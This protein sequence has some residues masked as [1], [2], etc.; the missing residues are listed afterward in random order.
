MTTNSAPHHF[1][2]RK[3]RIPC[4]TSNLGPGFDLLGLALSLW[5]EVELS[6]TSEAASSPDSTG[7]Q[8]DLAADFAASWPREN[9]LM[10]RAFDAVFA[11]Q[12]TSPP[13][14]HFRVKSEIPTAR[15]LGSSGAAVTAGLLL[16]NDV[17][18][19]WRGESHAMSTAELHRLGME[20]EGHPDN[21]TA[22]LFGGCTLC[23][24]PAPGATGRSAHDGGL[25]HAPLSSDLGFAVAW[26]DATLTTT[27]ARACLPTQVAFAD[28]VENPRRL[29]ML[30][31][32]L[33]TGNPKLLALGAEDRLHHAF[34]LALIPGGSQALQ[35]ATDAGAAMVA[36]NGSGSSLLAIGRVDQAEQLGQT[37]AKVLADFAPGSTSRNLTSISGQPT[38]E[39]ME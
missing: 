37:M 27:E 2:R 12:G 6:P 23:L 24:P 30:L 32:G 5:L 26:T 29:A 38:V 7:H 4:S 13:N 39:S 28:A 18:A 22:S 19:D 14:G 33:R 1:A 20:I 35:A 36:I 16:A 11:A 25:V 9:N 31:E 8:L 15:G 10:L 34:R 21:I 17:L 3:V